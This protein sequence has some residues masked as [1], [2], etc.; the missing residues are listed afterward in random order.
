MAYVIALPCMGIKDG[1]C[2]AVCPLDCIHP[3][4]EERAFQGAE[5]L[6]INPDTCI[7]CGLCSDECQMGA[8]FEEDA[9]PAEWAY[10]RQRNADYY[11]KRDR[12]A[13]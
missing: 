7:D 6:Y 8:I 11:A 9:L 3:T 4:A 1:R 5:M 2:I 13:V 10:F 12:R